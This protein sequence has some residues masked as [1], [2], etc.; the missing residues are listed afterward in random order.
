MERITLNVQ[1][2][3]EKGKGAARSLRRGAMIPAILYSGGGSLPIKIP[4]KEMTQFIN[5]TAGSQ[6]MVNLHFADGEN[7]L[8]LIKDYQVDPTKRELL[9]ADFFE[10][11]LTEKVRV[12]VHVTTTGEPIG[13]KRD[14]GILQNILRE[15]EVECLPDKIPGHIK[16]DI[17]GLEIGQFFH[18]GDLSLGEDVKILT[19]STEVLA[20]IIAP[21]VEEAAP[22]EVAAPEVA[23]P[24]VIKKGKKEEEAEE[25]K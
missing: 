20:N 6:V 4:K 5:T 24:E 2:R 15:I 1:K 16:I 9:H 17:S 25:S 12:S 13:V 21:L 7:K 3:E 10:V 19:D 14:K 23:E 8:A 11:S 18:V 22:A